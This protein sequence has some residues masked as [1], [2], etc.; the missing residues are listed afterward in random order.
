MLPIDL[1]ALNC[2][3]KLKKLCKYHSFI[4]WDNSQD[5]SS[6]T[7]YQIV[8]FFYLPSCKVVHTTGYENGPTP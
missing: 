7:L 8:L 3:T 1:N 2:L 6:K 5:K 4:F